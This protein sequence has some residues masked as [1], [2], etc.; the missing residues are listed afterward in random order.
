MR[1]IVFLIAAFLFVSL[2]QN[3]S[4]TKFATPQASNQASLGA[5]T[6]QADCTFDGRV[7]KEGEQ[8]KAF[9]NSTVA[10]GNICKSEIR[11]CQSGHLLGSF[12]Y[13]NCSVNAPAS[14]LL[15]GRNI[16]H[17]ASVTV[18]PQATVPYGASCT[19][20][21]RTCQNGT[22]IGGSGENFTCQPGM[23]RSCTFNNQTVAH[24]TSIKAF[25]QS[26][27]A[28]GLACASQDRYC[29]D[30]Q[31]NGNY[32]FGSCNFGA[33]AA[34]QFN[35][36]TIAHGASVN[37]YQAS[38]GSPNCQKE[39]KVCTNGNLSGS[40]NF[41]S[42]TTTNF[43]WNVKSFVFSPC[44]G[45]DGISCTAANEGQQIYQSFCG[46]SAGVPWTCDRGTTT[47]K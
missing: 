28:F 38:S 39:I 13:V 25:E 26:T 2:F 10:T 37:G 16:A 32:T 41:S 5:V 45:P 14:C 20:Q 18:Y 12:S 23:A 35:G 17:G 11:Q 21:T 47:Y 42:C 46:S 22:L 33:A 3:C 15:N 7:L 44:G 9:Q 4:K 27:V 19:S 8:V 24:G 1:P 29:N 40:Y 31:L 34:C 36:Q 30:G 43:N 6:L